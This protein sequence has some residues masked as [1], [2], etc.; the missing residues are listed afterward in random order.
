MNHLRK[1]KC[2]YNVY[3]REKSDI[4]AVAPMNQT[5]NKWTKDIF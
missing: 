4:F 3:I 5:E 2:L 1:K